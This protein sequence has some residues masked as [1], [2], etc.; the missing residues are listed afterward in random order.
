MDEKDVSD[1]SNAI[2]ISGFNIPVAQPGENSSS[3]V[4]NI[5]KDKLSINVS[6]VDIIKSFRIGKNSPHANIVRNFHVKLSKQQL[7]NDSIATS[8]SVKPDQ[9]FF[10]GSLSPIRNSIMY[11]LRKAKKDFPNIVSG[12]NSIYGSVYAWIKSPNHGAPGAR[13]SK[14]RI[15]DHNK[16]EY[17]CT[18]IIGSSVEIYILEWQH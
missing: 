15:N 14:M 6:P 11:V 12:C 17:F 3:V 9:L 1:R 4:R 5:L 8:R 18:E 2:I 10:N 13:D 7:K 16:L